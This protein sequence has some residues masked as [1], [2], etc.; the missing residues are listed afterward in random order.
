M[1]PKSSLF[2]G[3]LVIAIGI[4]LIVFNN[5][6]ELL[7][8]VVILAGLALIIPCVF[9]LANAINDNRRASRSGT[10]TFNQRM[11]TTGVIIT[12]IIGIGLGVWLVVSPNFFIG[13]I[14]YG[15][16]ILLILYGIYHLC[17]VIWMCRPLVLPAGFYIIPSLMIIAGLIILLTNVRYIKS[18]VIIITGIGLIGAGVSSILEYVA[19]GS[20]QRAIERESQ[21]SGQHK[22]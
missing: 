19:A 18:A 5:R 20:S 14:A 9:T 16:A 21:T 8:W 1:R 15:F 3:L 10:D 13:F 17:V 4:L 12:S 6:G 22:A 7:S 11:M 2:Y